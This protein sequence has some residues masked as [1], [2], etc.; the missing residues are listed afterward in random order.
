MRR[1]LGE[2]V[3]RG[4][5]PGRGHDA[6]VPAAPGFGEGRD[7]ERADAMTPVLALLLGTGSPAE[8]GAGR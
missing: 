4:P 3:G 7:E 2:L 1:A 5:D 6:N 8:P